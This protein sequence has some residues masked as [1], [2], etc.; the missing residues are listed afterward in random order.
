MVANAAGPVMNMY[1]LA[2]R[3][4]KEEFIATGAWFFFAINLTK[5]PV[6][7]AQGLIGAESLRRDALLLPVVVLGAWSGRAIAAKL[8]QRVFERAIV[9]LTVVAALLLLTPK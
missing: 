5:I 3:L 2:K 7:A 6:Y 4:P 8:P 9:A 1:L